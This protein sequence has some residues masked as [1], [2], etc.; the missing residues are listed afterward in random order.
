MTAF[1]DGAV[2]CLHYGRKKI[3]HCLSQLSDAQVWWRPREEMNSIGN[4]LLHLTGN[5]RQWIVA[6]VGEK[7]NSIGNLLLHLTGNIRQW[8]VAGVGDKAD[9][10]KRQAEFDERSE[11]KGRE[12]PGKITRIWPGRLRVTAHFRSNQQ[13]CIAFS[14]A[15]TRKRVFHLVFHQPCS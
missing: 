7:L 9:T 6:G 12:A 15:A 2:E 3:Q 11:P 10:R 13:A 1:S 5:I 4:L 14:S 8:I